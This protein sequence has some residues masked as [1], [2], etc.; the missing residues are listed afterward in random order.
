MSK[1]PTKATR[2]P[3]KSKVSG[4]QLSPGGKHSPKKQTSAVKSPRLVRKHSGRNANSSNN[5]SMAQ[6]ST[7]EFESSASSSDNSCFKKNKTSNAKFSLDKQIYRIS[8]G[9]VSGETAYSEVVQKTGD[10]VVQSDKDTQRNSQTRPESGYFSTDVHSESREGMEE[11]ISEGEVVN[12]IKL[13]PKRNKR[14]E[15]TDNVPESEKEITQTTVAVVKAS[16]K[17]QVD[18]ESLSKNEDSE[19]VNNEAQQMVIDN[20]TSTK[21]TRLSSWRSLSESEGGE[22]RSSQDDYFFDEDFELPING[23]LHSSIGLTLQASC[24]YGLA[25]SLAAGKRFYLHKIFV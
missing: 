25:D 11:S 15:Q 18:C 7:K 24:T 17:D 9:E 1:S 5:S 10:F 13:R 6:N 22:Q 3:V 2:S 4:S 21:R 16:N 19:N 14:S 8:A 20:E 12:T 23:H